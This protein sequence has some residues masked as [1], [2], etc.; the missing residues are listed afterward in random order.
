[1]SL[2]LIENKLDKPEP[3]K[4]ALIDSDEDGKGTIEIWEVDGEAFDQK[5]AYTY[6]TE[7]EE[8]QEI[9][10]WVKENG[11]QT[12]TIEVDY[13]INLGILLEDYGSHLSLV[14]LARGL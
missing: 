8:W 12:Q 7:P 4:V 11:K 1:M 5:V 14:H 10:D 6:P 2:T 13:S 9:A 3:S